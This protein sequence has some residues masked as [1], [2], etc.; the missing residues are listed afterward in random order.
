MAR[1]LANS[2]IERFYFHFRRKKKLMEITKMNVF[3]Y[4]EKKKELYMKVN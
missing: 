1:I 4:F 3:V 2:L